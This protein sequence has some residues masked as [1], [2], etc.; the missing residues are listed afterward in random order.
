MTER[1]KDVSLKSCSSISKLSIQTCLLQYKKQGTL[2]EANGSNIE[3]KQILDV[4]G[5]RPEEGQLPV[6]R[7]GR[8]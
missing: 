6:R 4:L 7:Q 3:N 8:C 2:D 5:N 1:R